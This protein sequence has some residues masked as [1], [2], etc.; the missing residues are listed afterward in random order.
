MLFEKDFD[1][2]DA[3]TLISDYNMIQ[4]MLNENI[5]K[6]ALEVWESEYDVVQNLFR[7]STTYQLLFDVRS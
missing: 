3:L 1:G 6:V 2:R 4:V 7:S 5:E